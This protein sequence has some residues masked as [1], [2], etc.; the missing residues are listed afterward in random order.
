MYGLVRG[1]SNEA[2]EP[3]AYATP[4]F[5]EAFSALFKMTVLEMLMKV[6]GY[7]TNGLIGMW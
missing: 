2:Y 6:D 3:R 5:E 4:A 1:G 7:I